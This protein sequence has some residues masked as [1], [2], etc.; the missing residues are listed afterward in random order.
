MKRIFAA[1][2]MLI[3]IIVFTACG[4]DVATQASVE[5]SAPTEETAEPE[6]SGVK[7]GFSLAGEGAFYDQLA[8][9]IENECAALGYA[10]LISSADTAEK[11]QEDIESMISQDVAVI[12]IDPVDIDAL[13]VVL[14]E[15]QTNGVHVISAIDSINGVF[16]TLISPNYTTI[17]EKA[18]ELAASLLGETG[19]G[20]MMLCTE[21]DSFTMQLIS[22]GF[23]SVIDGDDKVTLV[24]EQFCGQ[25][26][27][28]A[29]EAVKAEL[30]KGGGVDFI[31]AQN[32]A[33]GKGAYRAVDEQD[34]DAS[35][36]VIDGD[37]GTIE[38]V[39][40]G[41][42]HAAI[43]FGPNELAHKAVFYADNII[44]TEAYEAPKFVELGVEVATKENASGYVAGNESYAGTTEQD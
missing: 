11:Q 3:L 44:K 21:Y 33:L 28:E 39:S 31:F 6:P 30:E 26:E 14:A 32:E 42:I 43:F 8:A 22:D 36:V 12:T 29:Y 35:L 20:C 25:D 7:I 4:G 37:M 41:E 17:G 10:P 2:F 24:S 16:D 18:G 9:D 23:N 40:S 5:A 38:L 1:A 13:E 15:C 34:S 19:G 27:N